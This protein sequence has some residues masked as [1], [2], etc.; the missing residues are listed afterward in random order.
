MNLV[1]P[2]TSNPSQRPSRQFAVICSSSKSPSACN[3]LG[4]AS[5]VRFRGGAQLDDD[6][7]ES[8]D[9]DEEEEDEEDNLLDGQDLD[10]AEAEFSEE[11]MVGRTI[12]AWNKTPPLTKGYLTASFVAT[13]FGFLF[14]KNEFP[15]WLLLEWKALF[16]KFQIWRPL[17]AFL[18]FGPFGLGYVLT[19]QF[20]WTYMSQIERLH[21]SNPYDFWIMII[22]GQLSMVIGYPIFKLSPKFLGHNLSTFLV[23]NWSRIHE[24]AE[25]SLFDLVTVKAEL[26]PWFFL[27]Q[28]GL[29]GL[30]LALV[31]C[32]ENT[33][34]GFM[35]RLHREQ[36]PNSLVPF[37]GN[38]LLQ[39][40]TFL[41]EGEL[42]FLDFFGIVFG[43]VYHHLK[44][45]GT[46]KAPAVLVAW[47]KGDSDF[48]KSLRKKYK[49]ISQDYE[50]GAE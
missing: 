29:S 47:Y 37:V 43:H 33:W 6:D 50:L 9:E 23:Y 44:T 24:G 28:V 10:S 40:Q 30:W 35:V 25:V 5:L 42:P 31:P 8:E 39:Q 2:S 4:G 26:L 16:S 12:D 41:L 32:R 22:F 38:I 19:A 21:H 18:N 27:G 20:V 45:I 3:A 15:P 36:S 49:V 7:D 48:A 34:H 1:R 11:S 46:L 17:T 14:H 13:A